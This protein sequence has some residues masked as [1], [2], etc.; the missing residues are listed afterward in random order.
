MVNFKLIAQFPV[1]V[2]HSSL[3]G[4]LLGNSRNRYV[5]LDLQDSSKYF[6]RSQKCCFLDGHNSPVVFLFLQSLFQVIW[7][8]SCC[9]L[10]KVTKWEIT[11]TEVGNEMEIF[12]NVNKMQYL[13]TAW[14]SGDYLVSILRSLSRA[15]PSGRVW[16][17]AFL[18]V[19]PSAGP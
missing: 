1:L 19:G 9:N 8:C 6:N 15:P 10:T 7:H 18:K 13:P 11:K 14:T 12:I 3:T 17:K 4:G 2:F 16:Y 5:S